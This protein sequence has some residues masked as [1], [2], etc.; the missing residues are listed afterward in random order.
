MKSNLLVEVIRGQV[1]EKYFE[2]WV[3]VVNKD[4]QILKSLDYTDY[5][6]YMRSCEKPLQALWN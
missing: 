1:Q 5:K 6:C 4:K 2:G 3:I